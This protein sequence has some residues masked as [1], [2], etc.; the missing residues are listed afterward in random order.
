[1]GKAFIIKGIDASSFALKQVTLV[2]NMTDVTKDLI[3][4]PNM[5]FLH[6]PSG[7]NVNV[8]RSIDGETSFV[9]DV[10]AYV[11]KKIV[12]YIPSRPNMN[13]WWRVFIQ[14]FTSPITASDWS[15]ITGR[16]V[17]NAVVPCADDP[18]I[19]GEHPA[20]DTMIWKEVIVPADA[21]YLVVSYP[22]SL[23]DQVKVYAEP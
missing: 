14:S 1:M 22:S 12:M 4:H 23:A 6:Y 20:P 2:S 13:A 16:I 10:S 11:G 18:Y 7:G 17:E 19:G 8:L 5:M 21:V 15:S 3:V 9:L